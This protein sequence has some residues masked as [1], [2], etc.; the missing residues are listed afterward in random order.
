MHHSASMVNSLAAGRCGSNSKSAIF[1]YML[2]IEFK[3]ICEIVLTWIPQNT[4]DDKSTLVQVMAWCRQPTSYYLSQCDPRPMSPY[5]TTRPLWVNNTS[6][7]SPKYSQSMPG[8]LRESEMRDIFCELKSDTCIRSTFV[9][10]YC[11]QQC[12]LDNV[13]EQDLSISIHMYQDFIYI[14]FQAL[15]RQLKF[16]SSY[17]HTSFVSKNFLP[18]NPS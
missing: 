2:R 12:F 16:W 14:F 17:Y 9:T 10:S 13:L 3:S 8:S 1:K 18:G 11:S 15:S 4:F 7:F 5:G 6:Q